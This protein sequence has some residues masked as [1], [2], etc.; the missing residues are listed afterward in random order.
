MPSGQEEIGS[1]APPAPVSIERE[2]PVTP[3]TARGPEYQVVDWQLS[4]VTATKFDPHRQI[5]I[6]QVGG[7]FAYP[8]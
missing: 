6:L 3:E 7:I 1:V 2:K 8:T 4:P 5:G